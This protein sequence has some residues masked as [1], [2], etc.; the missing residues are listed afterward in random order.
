M[1]ATKT[2]RRTQAERTQAS[3]KKIIQSALETFTHKGF[4]GARLAD[5]AG[6]ANLTGPGLLHHFPNKTDLL[7][8]VLKE[9]DRVGGQLIERVLEENHD[10]LD[11]GTALVEH[12][13]TTPGIV[14]L[15][16]LLV[17][18][19]IS[20]D[21][22]AH[23]YFIERY[24]RTRDFW[25]ADLAEGQ[26]AGLVRADIPAESLAVIIFA[27]MDGLQ[28]QWLMEPDKIDMPG[29]FRAVMNLLRADTAG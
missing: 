29:L 21:H 15:F 2:P 26:R 18:E 13:Q 1:Q 27:L 20:P 24:Q 8:E 16:T 22:P 7:M 23:A 17:A 4:H 14:Q 3:R 6:A 5:I 9:R 10:I 11:A 28:I 12:N 19:S 25:V